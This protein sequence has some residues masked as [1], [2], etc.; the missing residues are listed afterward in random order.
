MIQRL[1]RLRGP[2]VVVT[3]GLMALAAASGA[4][5]AS[6]VRNGGAVT[7]VRTATASDSISAPSTDWRDVPG[8]TVSS[9]VPDSQRAL[10]VITFSAAMSCQKIGGNIVPFCGVRALVYGKVVEP[11]VVAVHSGGD[12][13]SG[14]TSS[15]QWIAGPLS[16]GPH[17]VKIQWQTSDVVN[18]LFYMNARTLTVMRS[19]V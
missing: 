18:E 8:L 3:V 5:A 1:Q 9:P 4:L 14:Q 15:M 2:G 11:G 6:L 7:A 16:S 19:R 10:L 13:S 12:Y 17:T